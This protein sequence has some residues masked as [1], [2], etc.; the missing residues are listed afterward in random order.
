MF[1]GTEPFPHLGHGLL[2]T[3]RGAEVPQVWALDLSLSITWRSVEA[4]VP[5]PPRPAESGALGEPGGPGQGTGVSHTT[6]FP[7]FYFLKQTSLFMNLRG[8]WTR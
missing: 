1:Q 7:P 4:R 8:G 6:F 3:R 5:A 2:V